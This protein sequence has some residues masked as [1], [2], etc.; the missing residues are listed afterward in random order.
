MGNSLL[1]CDIPPAQDSVGQEFFVAKYLYDSDRDV[2][3]A[4]NKDA[5]AQEVTGD[6]QPRGVLTVF[7]PGCSRDAVVV[8]GVLHLVRSGGK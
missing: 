3:I 2:P 6:L 8:L 7:P 4:E 1:F 5:L